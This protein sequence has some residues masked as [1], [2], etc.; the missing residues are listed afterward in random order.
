MALAPLT[1]PQLQ[2]EAARRAAAEAAAAKKIIEDA[3]AAAARQALAGQNAILGAGAASAGIMQGIGPGIQEGYNLAGREIS[4]IAGGFSTE[5]ANRVRAAQQASQQQVGSIGGSYTG[6]D[7]DK[8]KDVMFGVGGFI[9][10]ASLATQ[11]AAARRWGEVLPGIETR[12]TQE[13]HLGAIAKQ[14]TDDKE[15][16]DKLLEIAAKEPA[17]RDEILDALYKHELDKLN[18]SVNVRQVKVQERAQTLYE[19]QFPE[20]VR[21]AKANE[22]IK[23][24][25]LTLKA[26]KQAADLKK[27]IANGA[28]PN[29]SLSKVYGYVVDEYGN[30]ITGSDGKRIAVSSKPSAKD[31]NKNY[32]RSVA[33]AKSLRG[34]PVENDN[35]L[36]GGK[37]KARP[38]AKNVLW[39]RD[40][41]GKRIPGSAS[42]NDP[43]KALYDNDMSFAAAQ[44]YLVEA[45]GLK[46]A[47]ARAAL[48]AAGW[49]PDGKRP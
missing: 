23:I 17:R 3:R 16:V 21:A 33:E 39:M 30:P 36:S 4:D 31:T 27:E 34:D 29:A 15:Y 11:G 38:G 1:D 41:N 9:P 40:A 49:K 45:Y 18:A 2:D 35:A 44:A 48:I 22:R 46:P 43:K 8:M 7:A 25:G 19:K 47:R 10:G 37:Y 24:A 26:Q 14:S 5:M 28:K 20:K 13:A 42:T 32:Q 6:V 12:R